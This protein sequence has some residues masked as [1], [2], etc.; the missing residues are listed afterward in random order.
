MPDLRPD[1]VVVGGGVAGLVAARD[2]AA[3]GRSVL[4]LEGSPEVGGKLRLGTIAGV[5][6]DV[7]AESMLARRPEA[8]GL[9]AELGID[10]VHPVAGSSQ[11]W[12]RGAMRPLPRTLLGVPLDLDQL[13]ASAVLSDEG[14]ER[15]RH[16]KVR[17][18]EEDDVSVADLLGSRLGPEV[19]DRLAEPLLG[20][21]YAGH[22]SNLSAYAA[23]PQVVALLREHGSLLAA[24]A[25]VPPAS[26]EPVFAGIAG[27]LGLLP[28]ALCVS[29]GVEVRTSAPV[30]GL[31]RARSG[32]RLT[33]G[34]ARTPETV[35]TGQVVL[36]TPAAPTARLLEETAPD[37]AG[38]LAAIEYASM[39]IVTM[40][41]RSLEVDGSSGF[42]VPAVD[43]RQIKAA[44]YS[45]SKWE[46]VGAVS[47]LRILRASLGRHRE[48]ATLQATDDELVARVVADL[49]AATGQPIEP[50]DVHVQRWGGALPQYAVGHLD[51]VARIRRA[52]AEVPGL[53]V[54]GAAYDGVGIPAVI[55]SARRAAARMAAA[56]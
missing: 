3:G 32:F 26:E 24:A 4:V 22:A 18:L 6:V 46:W 21:V 39:A 25:A 52:V 11:L 19:V 55:G 23:M 29:P 41:V 47:D 14:L 50:V 15:A 20:G 2:L 10:L 1:A 48:E 7:G 13:A 28:R 54:C 35:D 45:F 51:R 40:A 34:S 56:E 43:G 12:T 37:A 30:R 49:A 38:E 27:G 17:P 31:S 9:V 33:V 16:E 5:Q 8:V 36:A 42:L 44:T 53:E